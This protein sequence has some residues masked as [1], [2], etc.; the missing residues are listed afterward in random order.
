M[1]LDEAANV[2]ISVVDVQ[3]K[4]VAS[5]NATGQAETTVD[6]STLAPG[7]YTVLISTENGVA[8]K[9]VVVE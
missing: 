2:A 3:G 6:A 4:V 8:T 7:I 5:Q 9:K 1:K